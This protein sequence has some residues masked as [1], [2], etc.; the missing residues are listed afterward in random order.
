MPK[1]AFVVFEEEKGKAIHCH[2]PGY[3]LLKTHFGTC[4]FHLM[5]RHKFRDG[6]L[7]FEIDAQTDTVILLIK[8]PFPASWLSLYNRQYIKRYIV[9][10]CT[11]RKCCKCYM[12]AA[13]GSSEDFGTYAERKNIRTVVFK[14]LL[15]PVLA[16]IYTKRGL[17]LDSLDMVLVSGEDTSELIEMVRQLE[18]FVRYMSIVSSD[19]EAVERELADICMESGV[20]VI[21]GDN[22]KS[23]L[24]NADLVIN[25][26]EIAAI[27]KLRIRPE[28]VVIHFSSLSGTAAK[29]EYTFISGVEYTFPAVWYKVFGEDIN[30]N[31]S[32]SELTE[33]LMA[34][35]AGLFNGGTYN[36]TMAAEIQEVFKSNCCR[37]TGFRG[38]R[39]VLK[40]EN[41]LKCPHLY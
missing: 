5:K 25:L 19:K 16:E 41:V 32:K 4:L 33:I 39:G 17:R 23:M 35:K 14:A 6:I 3:G 22:C 31:Y 2:V 27:S 21:I 13:F 15:V 34:F 20:S 26:G 18:P 38:R 40:V 1:L 8:L 28:A 9:K 29:G 24:R 12:P 36:E 7:E 10:A 30:K 37:I 11:G